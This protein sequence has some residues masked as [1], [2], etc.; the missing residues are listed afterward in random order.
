MDHDKYDRQVN[1]PITES[2]LN[3]DMKILKESAPD[4]PH[5]AF[6]RLARNYLVSMVKDRGLL[7]V[8]AEIMESMNE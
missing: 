1:V 8:M 7:S 2:M 6:Y 4:M 5:G 3:E